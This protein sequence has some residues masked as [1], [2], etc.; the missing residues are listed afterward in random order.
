ML[1][2]VQLQQPGAA[3]QGFQELWVERLARGVSE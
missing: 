1:E 3:L 2:F